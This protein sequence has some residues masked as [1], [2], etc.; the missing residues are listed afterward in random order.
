MTNSAT[1]FRHYGLQSTT[2]FRLASIG[3][4]ILAL[5]GI[6][7]TGK[8]SYLSEEIKRFDPMTMSWLPDTVDLPYELIDFATVMYK[9][10]LFLIGGFTDQYLG[11]KLRVKTDFYHQLLYVSQR[12]DRFNRP[13]FI[14]LETSNLTLP[15]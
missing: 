1:S 14:K 9:D 7:T 2:C 4:N 5:G 3:S 12:Y 11:R 15:A 8:D 13:S 10:E 6:K